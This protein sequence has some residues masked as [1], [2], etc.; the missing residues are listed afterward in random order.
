MM[1]AVDVCIM[2]WCDGQ[3]QRSVDG[4]FAFTCPPSHL[5]R[6]C[7]PSD[8]I[9]RMDGIVN[10]INDMQRISDSYTYVLDGMLREAGQ[11]KVGRAR[12]ADR[13]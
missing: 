5:T 6:V 11:W 13:Q 4:N 3:H 7:T 2:W 1:R 9:N 10:Y 12:R 8:A